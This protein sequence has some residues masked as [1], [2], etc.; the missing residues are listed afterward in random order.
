MS[1]SLTELTG[2][3]L[4]LIAP[5][6]AISPGDLHPIGH[7]GS[8]VREF[9]REGHHY[10]LRLSRCNDR[11]LDML[12][13]EVDW[14]C[15]LSANGIS[16]SVPVASTAGT[17]IETVEVDGALFAAVVSHAAEGRPLV[18]VL[19]D[20]DEGLYERWGNLV[21]RMHHL[22]RSYAPSDARFRRP[23][24]HETDDLDVDAFI[25]ASEQDVLDRCYNLLE[26]LKRLPVDGKSYGLIHA[27]LHRRNIFA[28]ACLLTVIDF[29]SCQYCW[30]AYDIAVCLYHAVLS[31]PEGVSRREFGKHFLDH[32]MTGYSKAHHLES[33]R[34]KWLPV[35]LR[36]RRV[37]MYVD[38]L[39]Y[40]DLHGLSP[41]R[42]QFLVG[43]RN[44]IAADHPVL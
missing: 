42:E 23:H 8:D 36:L 31:A 10:V 12:H 40:W 43:L 32:F 29:D 22:T 24:W 34:L 44:A 5:R 4:A 28:D 26:V 1:E 18:D 17:L 6:Y 27:D 3:A 19:E 15:Y 33:D 39:R 25:P 21:G 16:V 9:R 35:F 37:V 30:F 13:G 11:R 20:W 41:N 14:I 7:A 2:K 38:V